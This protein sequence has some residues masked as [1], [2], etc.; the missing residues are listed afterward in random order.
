[1]RCFHKA[2]KLERAGE[3]LATMKI[4]CCNFKDDLRRTSSRRAM[5]KSFRITIELFACPSSF[6]SCLIFFGGRGERENEYI[7]NI[8]ER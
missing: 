5:R 1:M 3:I 8:H 6:Q 7:Y 2:D 4:Q